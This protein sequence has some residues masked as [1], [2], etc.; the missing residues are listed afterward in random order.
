MSDYRKEF[1]H[2]YYKEILPVLRTLEPD[3]QQRL[4]QVL[5]TAGTTFGII[6][7]L[8]IYL[9]VDWLWIPI[10]TA[11][12]SILCI[13]FMSDSF[14]SDLKSTYLKKI[15][16]A[17]GNIH[18]VRLLG[19][20]PAILRNSKLF[21]VFDNQAVDDSFEG[22]YNSVF[23]RVAEASLQGECSKTVFKGLILL[24]KTNK[25]IRNRTIVATKHD[26][27]LGKNNYFFHIFYTALF[28]ILLLFTIIC[29]VAKLFLFCWFPLALLIAAIIGYREVASKYSKDVRYEKMQ[30]IKLEDPRFQKKYIALSSDEVEGRYLI[31]TAFMERFQ[32]LQTTFGTNKIKCA[33]IDN[34]IVFAI[35]NRKNLFEIGNLFHSLTDIKIME[36]FFDEIIAIY[37][38][39][40]HFKLNE[41]IRL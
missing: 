5:L 18:D 30:E 39:I 1:F 17:L 16:S 10:I 41:Q 11:L 37:L 32:N 6:I 24:F 34:Y 27:G 29:F 4:K 12:I 20:E 36:R 21:P 7:P 13:M 19:I 14:V 3:R 15:L 28:I 33:F 35:S 2:T 31:T 22:S 25:K 26:I 38:L 40:D 8:V 23:F 9:P